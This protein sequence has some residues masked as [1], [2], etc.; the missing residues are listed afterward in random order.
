MQQ[1]KLNTFL[2][3][4]PALALL[5]MLVLTP[6]LAVVRAGWV[7]GLTYLIP[8]VVLGV[9]AGYLLTV[10]DL[11]DLIALLFATLYGLFLVWIGSA[12][13]ILESAPFRDRLVEVIQ[14]VSEWLL[15]A[16][17][18]GFSRDNFIF[19][20]LLALLAWYLAYNAAWNLFGLR[21]FWQAVLPAGLALL[22]TL[23]FYTGREPLQWLL[24]AFL[25]LTFTLAAQTNAMAR[26]RIWR[27]NNIGYQRGVRLSLVRAGVIAIA[28]L[29]LAAWITPAASATDRLSGLLNRDESPWK[30]VEETWQRLFGGVQTEGG[31]V[32][33]YYAGVTL[34]MGGPVSLSD[35][36]VMYVYAPEGYRYYWRSKLFDTYLE[37]RWL[38]DI[39]ARLE[40]DYGIL[41]AEEDAAYALRRNVQ[42]TFQLVLPSTRLL[43]AAPQPVSFASLPISYQVA[44]NAPGGEFAT[45]LSVSAA[46]VLR[47]GASYGAISSISIADEASLRRAGTSY[48]DWVRERY[49]SVPSSITPRTRDLAASI[50]APYDNP[51]DVARA[52]EGWLRQNITYN[53]S[54]SAPPPGVEPIDYLLFERPEGYCTYYASAMAI[55]LRTQGIP[56]RVA[57]GFAQGEYVENLG[58]YRV[59]E[60]DAHAWVEAYFP[61]YGWVEFEPTASRA[62]ITRSEGLQDLT[63]GADEQAFEEP[64]APESAAADDLDLE[65]ERDRLR[66]EAPGGAAAP[67]RRGIPPVIRAVFWLIVGVALLAGVGW[68]WLEMRG[69]R[70]LS[71]V[72]R[73]YARLNI[74]ASLL[75]LRAQPS[76]TPYERARAIARLIPENER[77]AYQITRLYVDE[78][79]GRPP[80]SEEDRRRAAA[81]A[82]GAWRTARPRF[83]RRLLRRAATILNP[84]RPRPQAEVVDPDDAAGA[85][86]RVPPPRQRR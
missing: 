25:F 52:I 83:L 76:V 12:L 47:S 4:L 84:F 61:T 56:A 19:L 32:P 2:E 36:A 55:M 78:Q 20:F 16:F 53:E 31:P 6:A 48:P 69:L 35:N 1:H 7:E 85:G 51:Y 79:Y 74:F 62:P 26:E 24:I 10:S 43:Y 59:A 66:E 33:V 50:A 80:A 72:S 68:Y 63:A 44:Y 58:A 41:N 37:G 82:R 14:R 23:Y 81:S 22:V 39:D 57:A 28:A 46:D 65:A 8:V 64:Q 17:T 86:P 67:V 70:R 30:V 13:L 75:G 3:E 77:E 11:P 15:A 45:V 54:V 60:S 29:L 18:G 21:R 5:L 71:E 73:S 38:S 42:Q 40:A 49:L 9:I 34:A 27:H